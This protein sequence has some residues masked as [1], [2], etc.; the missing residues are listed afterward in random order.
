MD[1]LVFTGGIGKH[2]AAVREEVCAGL[3]HLGLAL[4]PRCNDANEDTIS[5]ADSRCRV[6][7]VP[8]DENLM[9]A[10]HSVRLVFPAG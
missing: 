8:T 6:R 10:W 9:V 3:T 7:V 5:A 2:A 1:L 4:D